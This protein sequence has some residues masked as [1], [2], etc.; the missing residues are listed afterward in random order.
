MTPS[1]RP[2]RAILS[3][4][5]AIAL[6]GLVPS[7]AL[8]VREDASR[9][10]AISIGDPGLAVQPATVTASDPRLAAAKRGGWSSFKALNGGAWDV[11]LDGRSGAP[12]L[13]QGQG[14]AFIPGTGNSLQAAGPVTAQSL[15][16]QIRSFMAKNAALLLAD[17]KELVLNEEGS[18]QLTADLWKIVF[19]RAVSGI[20]VDGDRYIFYVGHGNLIAFGAT[21]WSAMTTDSSPVLSASDGRAALST[22]MG[23]KA[24]DAVEIQNAGT[25]TIVPMAAAGTAVDGFDGAAGTGYRTALAWRIAFAVEGEPGLWVGLVDAHTGAVLALYDDIKYAQAKGGTF[26]LSDDGSCPTGCEQANYPMPWADIKIGTTSSSAGGMGSFSCSPLGST[27]T[28]KLAG[29]YVRV[30]DTCGTISQTVS[31]DADLD[32]GTSSGTDCTIPAGASA[33]DTHAARSSFYHLNRIKEHA[34]AWLPGK[35]WLSAQLTDNVNIN[36][37]CNAFW[38]SGG[39]YGTVNFYRSGG[40]C[41]NTGEIAGVF[42]HEWGHGLDQND[43]GGYDNPSEAYADI[44]SFL[45]THSSCIGR[46]FYSSGTCNGYGNACLSCTGIR[47]QDWNQRANRTPSTP[48]G[49]IAGCSTQTVGG[50]PCGKEPHCEA[51]L[52]AETLWDL[53]NRDLTAAGMDQPTAWLTVDRLWYKSR[54]ASGGNAYSCG[55]TASLRSCASGSWFTELRTLDD[56]DGNLANGTPHAAAIF[57]SFNRH[58]IPCGASTDA[59][60][61]SSTVCSP[62][63]APVLT[64]TPSFG[65]NALSWTAVPGAASYNVFRNDQ[66]C[67]WGFTLIANVTG[68]TYTDTGLPNAFPLYYAVQAV[69]SNTAC[70]GTLG[71]CTTA[72]AGGPHAKFASSARIADTCAPGGAGS[73]NGIYD[74]GEQ[75]QFSITL[76]NDGNA[77]LTG[78]T[79]T[80]TPTTPGVTMVNATANWASIASGASGTSLAPHFTALLSMNLACGSAVNYN[81]TISSNEGTWTGSFFQT[82]GQTGAGGG[83]PISESFTAGIP[84]SWT[85]V[86]GG[87]GGGASATWTTANPCARAFSVPIASPAAMVDSACAGASAAQE[88]QLVTPII[89]LSSAT[90]VTLQYDE[91]FRHATPNE[92]G[93]V[94]VKSSA[95]GGAWTNVVRNQDSDTNNPNHR[96]VDISAQAA[97]APDAQIRFHYYDGANDWYWQVDNVTVTWSGTVCSMNLCISPTSADMRVTSSAAPASVATHQNVTYT[98]TVSNNGPATAPGPQLSAATPLGTTFQ[99]VAAPPG[100]S[101]TTPAV[102]GT[103]TVSCSKASLATGSPAVFTLVANVNWCA[104]NGTTVSGNASVTSGTADPFLSNNSATALATVT[105]SGSCDDGNPCTVS[106]LC[107]NGVCAGTPV[108]PAETGDSLRLTEGPATTTISWTEGAGTFN[109]YRGSRSSVAWSYNHTCLASAVAGPVQDPQK[110]ALGPTFYYLLTRVSSCGESIPGRDSL[111][112]PIPNGQPCP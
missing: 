67:G 60:N 83:T 40:G 18:G 111:G 7:F 26:P 46:G 6:A 97:G 55:P 103:G 1:H 68:T 96:T 87:S 99:S 71:A 84:G 64:T 91:Y 61:L 94:D 30:L 48:E 106:D 21:R 29:S 17:D 2:L 90:T 43:N 42:L 20:P 56:D 86:D 59:T 44:T 79:A 109:L 19:D 35:A 72:Q 53:A 82:L 27:A 51:Y 33:G 52:T 77:A 63:A 34:R 80:V 9:F 57:T 49:F 112:G 73:N 32:L 66:G 23:L 110:P 65:A 100:W 36:N 28:T 4:A 22:Y 92:T 5:A 8:K 24:T 39:S 38:S 58:N 54:N 45:L 10:D 102:G 13:V 62:L 81:I 89:D 107:T 88:E 14:I 70:L 69:G 11:Y 47:D 75:I 41:R 85:V 76:K 108:G 105:D 31:C 98:I 93:D 12:L 50:G 25:L 74:A 104:G 95:T 3:I 37:T 16:G 78:V 101:C 15:A